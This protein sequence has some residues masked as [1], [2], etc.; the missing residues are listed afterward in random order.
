MLSASLTGTGL[1]PNRLVVAAVAAWG[2]R[3]LATGPVNM[4]VTARARLPLSI[5]RRC[6]RRLST[7]AKVELLEWLHIGSSPCSTSSRRRAPCKMRE[8][9]FLRLCLSVM[10]QGSYRAAQAEAR[11]IWSTARQYSGH[12]ITSRILRP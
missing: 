2:R 9:L 7:S 6:K 3:L 5:D 10:D 11:K 4:E 8:Y 1:K 12:T